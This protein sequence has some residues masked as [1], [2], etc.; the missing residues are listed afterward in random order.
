MSCQTAFAGQPVWAVRKAASSSQMFA[1]L[2]L[3]LF[4]S[5]LLLTVRPKQVPATCQCRCGYT[6]VTSAASPN[7]Q[8][9]FGKPKSRSWHVSQSSNVYPRCK[10]QAKACR[11]RDLGVRELK[12]CTQNLCCTPGA[13]IAVKWSAM[14]TAAWVLDI[15]AK[16]NTNATYRTCSTC[17]REPQLAQY[18]R[19][20][21][22]TRHVAASA[23]RRC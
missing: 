2:H 23:Q 8:L 16:P 19:M 14:F 11:V 4:R 3:S 22:L 6:R 10:P 17:C 9:M 15:S 18:P 1:L 20:R 21:Q 5:T 7:D 13:A 12:S